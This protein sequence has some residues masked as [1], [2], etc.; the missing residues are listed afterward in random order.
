[1]VYPLESDFE[2]QIIELARL[3]GWLVHAERPA[4]V[5]DGRWRTPIRGDDGWPDL[6]MVRDGRM[7]IAELKSAKGKVSAMQ[8]TWLTALGQTGAEVYL[9][10]P[11]DWDTIEEVLR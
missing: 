1:M 8:Q 4:L 5:K 2:T 9:W 10:K 7:V 6:V 11:S 3:Q